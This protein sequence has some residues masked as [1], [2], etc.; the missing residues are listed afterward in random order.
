MSSHAR[1][2]SRRHTHAKA[3]YTPAQLPAVS[4]PSSSSL[5]DS[6]S[7]SFLLLFVLVCAAESP[8][9]AQDALPS[10]FSSSSLLHSLTAFS[11]LMHYLSVLPLLLFV[12]FSL[13]SD[14]GSASH[15]ASRSVD[16]FRLSA[17]AA[18]LGPTPPGSSTDSTLSGAGA[19]SLGDGGYVSA[20]ST[21]SVDEHDDDAHDVTMPL[22]AAHSQTGA[23]FP[24]RRSHHKLLRS[25][26]LSRPRVLT[27]FTLSS[28]LLAPLFLHS[29]AAYRNV[30]F[31]T[32]LCGARAVDLIQARRKATLRAHGTSDRNKLAYTH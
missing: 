15:A 8:L 4:P 28:L 6:Y 12:F 24:L 18:A 22:T 5:A 3:P 21:A 29:I 16:T 30:W 31:V 11:S 2:N 17:S 32:L 1:R 19:A 27:A 20:G 23:F 13:H 14:D 7:R 26:L 9:I 10:A 25:Y